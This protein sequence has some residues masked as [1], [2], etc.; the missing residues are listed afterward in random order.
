MRSWS[1]RVL[2]WH[3]ARQAFLAELLDASAHLPHQDGWLQRIRRAALSRVKNAGSPRENTDTNVP[4]DF[5]Q[6]NRWL[7]AQALR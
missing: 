2:T 5:R 6:A 7:R 4:S 3:P 1:V